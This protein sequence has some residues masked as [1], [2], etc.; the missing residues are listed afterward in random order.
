MRLRVNSM[1]L[2]SRSVPPPA[3]NRQADCF[4]SLNLPNKL[5]YYT[6]Y[7]YSA[8]L[9]ECKTKYIINKCHCVDLLQPGAS[10]GSQFRYDVHITTLSTI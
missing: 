3:D 7:S 5:E 8:C 6:N 1:V 4:D 2:Q 9:T 10:C